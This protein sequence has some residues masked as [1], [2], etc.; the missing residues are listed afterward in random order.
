MALDFP[1]SPSVTD[2]HN[3]ANGLQYVFDGVKWISQGRYDTGAINAEKLDN[4]S[5]NFNGVLTTFNLK[6]N[7][8]TVKPASAE[9]LHIVLAGHLQE[10]S[11]AYTINSVNGTITFASAPSNG[12]A[13]FGVVLS[14]L[15]LA[16]TTGT[17]TITNANVAANAAIDGTKINPNFGS[18]T[19]TGVTTTQSAT[20]NTTKL[21][22]T[23]FVQTAISNL[24]DSS[25]DALNTLNELAAALGDDADFSTTITTALAAKAP[26]NSPTFTGTVSGI[27]YNDLSN[28]PTIPSQLTT[29]QVQDIVGAM[30]TGNTETGISVTYN[31][32]GDGTGK[33]NF[34]TTTSS[35]SS[36]TFD[37]N[38]KAIFGTNND[39]LEIYHDG[40]NSII[41]DTGTGDLLLFGT[42]IKLQRT[43][44]TPESLMIEAFGGN[45]VKLYYDG[46]LKFETDTAG[47]KWSGDLFADAFTNSG[48]GKIKM[49]PSGALQIYHD[50]TNSIIDDSGTGSLL[51]YGS[52]VIIQESGTS[53]VM[54]DFH[55]NTVKLY[56]NNKEKLITTDNG[57]EIKGD[58]SNSTDG[59]IQLNCSANSH[60]V[61]IKSPNHSAGQSYTIILPD[62]QIAVNKILKVKSV[63]GSGSTAIGQLEFADDTDTT[64]PTASSSTLGGIKVGTNLSIDGN[65]VLSASSGTTVGGANGVSFNDDIRI[66]FGGTTNEKLELFYNASVNRGIITA[67]TGVHLQFDGSTKIESV[68]AGVKW[69]GDLFCDDSISGDVNK[70]RLGNSADLEIYHDS[71]NSI[72]DAT[73]NGSLLFYASDIIFHEKSDVSHKIAEFSQ[74]SSTGCKLYYD[75]S[76]K[77]ETTN[78]GVSVSGTISSGDITISDNNPTLTFSEGDANPDYR[79]IAN[80][81]KLTFQ[82]VTN[83]FAERL[84]INTDGHIDIAGNLDV[85]AGLDVTGNITVSGTVDGVDI[86]ALNT[87]VSGIASPTASSINALYED[88]GNFILGTGSGSDTMKLYYDGTHGFIT[89]DNGVQLQYDGST[90]FQTTNNG[91]TVSGRLDT[92][93]LFTGDNN[94]ILIGN[95]DDLQLH[96]DGT[97]SYIDNGQGDLNLRALTNS[98]TVQIIAGSEYMARFVKDGAVELY[99]GM[100]GSAASKKFETTSYGA[101]LTGNLKLGDNGKVTFGDG[102]DLQFFHDGSNSYLKEAGT[103][104]VIHEVTDA[105]IEFKKGGSEHLAKFIPD[106]S[107]QLYWD[108]SLKFNTTA[109][110]A[111]ITG[112][113]NMT[114]LNCTSS[115]STGANFTVGGDLNVTGN[116]DVADNV[117]IKLGTGDDLEI[118][119]DGSKSVVADTGTGGLFVAA[120]S[121]SFT[122]AGITETMLYAVP[123]GSVLLYWDNSLK[124]ETLSSGVKWHGDLFCDD[125]QYLKLG[126]SADLQLYHDGSHSYIKNSTNY[127]YYLSTQHL[128]KNVANNELQAKFQENA[129]AQ[130]FYDNDSKLETHSGGVS[131]YGNLSLT[132]AD[133]HE[134]RLGASSDLKLYHNGSASYI[135]NPSHTLYIQATTIDIGNGAGNEA[136]AKFIDNGSVKLY[137]DNALKFETMSSGAK[138]HGDLY[139]DDNGALKFGSSA[140]LVLYHDSNNSVIADN[141]TGS[142]L[143][144]TSELLIRKA[145]SSET[146]A[147]FVQD[148]VVELYF[149]NAAKLTTTSSGITVLGSVTETSDIALKS[150]IQPLTN[151]LE[152]LQQITGYKYNLINSISPSMGVIAQDVEKVFPE[153][154]HGSEGKKA[155]QYS[156]LIGVLVEAVKELSA[157]VAAL[158]AA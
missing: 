12:T 157:K 118:Y 82:D 144:F 32:A 91:A 60:G 92:Q 119:H 22:S 149:D 43:N 154:V 29:E 87:T 148:G 1:S 49:G 44:S 113:C 72:I 88:N 85:G 99:H 90:K 115:G 143:L 156:G 112:T 64:L 147:K 121:L 122:N 111:T 15:P 97:N 55:P 3:A 155:L 45:A 20:D 84:V 6:V 57:I 135:K 48:G 127:T 40:N 35:S 33:L 62:N 152:K 151:T 136:K 93:G 139:C 8:I 123:D 39:G 106:G 104:N 129:G 2:I 34:A 132:S 56:K 158:E 109:T 16:D 4:I 101:L 66:I 110:G 124:L 89:A 38:V 116:I 117:K 105:T 140:D 94:K 69:H 30:V 103:G 146:M 75:N 51:V 23:A 14:R 78:T 67:N 126:S 5:S 59:S 27:S 18:N 120:S 53:N 10:P 58:S 41:D 107:V 31:D 133:G 145:G 11:T 150:N 100:S 95:S 42:S 25:P 70:I 142:L 21:A 77:F 98:T 83:S 71:N 28:L 63:S 108:N 81:G 26:L 13:F 137:H 52:N 130:L 24:V 7:N 37:D 9:S 65:G 86:A 79:I 73:G 19:I 54:A 96:H 46:A 114:S 153:L 141:G 80:G 74:D 76:P 61:K 128:F 138:W 36:Q 68:N 131:I 102:D 17:S 47:A 134:L 125:S 50:N